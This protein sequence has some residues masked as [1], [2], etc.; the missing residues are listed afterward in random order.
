MLRC[1][2]LFIFSRM[3]RVVEFNDNGQRSVATVSS[4]WWRGDSDDGECCWPPRGSNTTYMMRKHM[5]PDA[6]WTLH[7]AKTIFSTGE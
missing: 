1:I 2:Y 5:A 6:A 3:F 4:A 7:P